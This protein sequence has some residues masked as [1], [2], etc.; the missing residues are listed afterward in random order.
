MP[1]ALDIRLILCPT[2]GSECSQVAAARAVALAGC[3]GAHLIG[4]YVIDTHAAVRLGI[5]YGEAVG[6]LE[7]EGHRALTAL[8]ERAAAAGVP[9]TRLLAAGQP[10]QVILEVARDRGADLIVMGAH[11]RSGLERA[12]LGSVSEHVVRHSPC[13]VLV[14]RRPLQ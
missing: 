12:I 6:E 13:D 9:F 4:L 14:V 3:S 10:R 2:D 7:A 11:G 8:E 1:A 5:H